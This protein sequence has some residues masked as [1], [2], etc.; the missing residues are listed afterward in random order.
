MCVSILLSVKWKTGCL[1]CRGG[2][3][4]LLKSGKKGDRFLAALSHIRNL[5]V[6]VTVVLSQIWIHLSL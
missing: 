6:N 1:R 4:G 2:I 5:L 3:F